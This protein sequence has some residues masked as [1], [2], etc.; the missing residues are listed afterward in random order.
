MFL[1]LT[2]PMSK[3]GSLKELVLQFQILIRISDFKYLEFIHEL[4]I[5]LINEVLVLSHIVGS[6][7]SKVF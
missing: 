3:V 1:K 7:T 2:L 5:P 6:S 4:V